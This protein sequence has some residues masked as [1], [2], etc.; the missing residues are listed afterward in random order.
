[1]PI[2]RLGDELIFP[3]ADVAEPNGFLA[4]GGD[5]SSRRLLLAYSQGIFPWYSEGEP[6]LWF[7]PDPRMLL[8]PHNLR[9]SRGIRRTLSK[10][11]F[12][13]RVDTSF[14]S[15][16]RSCAQMPRRDQ[17]GTWI[18]GDMIEAYCR[19]HELGFAH[20]VEAWLEGGLV[21]GVYG[22]SIGV[23]FAAESM[24]H[25]CSGASMAALIALVEH[26]RTWPGALVDC[27]L[28][29]PHLAR[30]G[31]QQWPRPRFLAALGR[32]L[33][34]ETRLGRWCFDR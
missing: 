11:S 3:P 16:I 19:L 27:Q 6:I 26:L 14:E 28:H 18:T 10:R 20:S 15:V 29:T 13:I 22:V 17:D 4:I 23:Y 7:S 2:Y 12:E 5:L 9:I 33:E 34:A 8:E 31:A 21:G 1:M 30:L 32:A 24:F 25:S